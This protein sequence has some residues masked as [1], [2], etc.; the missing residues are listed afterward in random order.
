M[1]TFN[2]KTYN[3]PM[4]M[5]IVLIGGECKALL[6]WHLSLGHPPLQWA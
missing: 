5:A 1:I 2:E 4:E 6:L 3:C